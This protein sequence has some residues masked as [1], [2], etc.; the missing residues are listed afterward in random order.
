MDGGLF[1]L[2]DVGDIGAIYGRYIDDKIGGGCMDDA[3][4]IYGRHKIDTWT[5]GTIYRRYGQYMDDVL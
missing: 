4:T 5:I 3:W 2:D 1:Y